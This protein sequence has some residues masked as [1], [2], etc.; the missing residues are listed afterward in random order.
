MEDFPL[1][2]T[3]AEREFYKGYIRS[4]KPNGYRSGEITRQE[5]PDETGETPV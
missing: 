3:G 5:Y 2:I 4:P 1:E